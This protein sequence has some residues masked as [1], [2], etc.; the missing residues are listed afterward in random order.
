MHQS[1]AHADLRAR[2]DF[3]AQGESGWREDDDRRS[4]LKPS[5]LL[6]LVKGGVARYSIRAAIAKVQQD[7][8]EVEPDAGDQD[9]RHRHQRDRQPS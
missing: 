1:A 5:Q 2:P 8:D 4:M 7:I 9:G 3:I 6:A